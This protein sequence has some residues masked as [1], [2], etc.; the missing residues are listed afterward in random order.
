MRE[1][2]TELER[3]FFHAGKKLPVLYIEYMNYLRKTKE[4]APGTINNRKKPVL[5]FIIRHSSKCSPSNIKRVTQKEVQDYT[6]ETAAP[7]SRNLKRSLVIALRD[8][9][10][11][12]HLYEHTN[13]DLSLS[14]PT[15]TTYRMSAIPRGMPWKTVEK[16]LQCISKRTFS[17][18]RDY[19]IVLTLSRY[20][21]RA[22]QLRELKL[23]DIDWHNET[24]TF[25][26]VKGG[27][28]VVAPLYKDVAEAL[29]SYIKSGRKNAPIEYENVF[30]TS[31]TGGS[32]TM[33]QVPLNG[34]TWN[35]INRY[36]KKAGF[37][38]VIDHA[39]GPHAIRHAFATRLL[40][41]DTPI[42]TISDMIGHNSIA[43][44]FIYTKTSIPKLK[45]LELPWP[46]PKMGDVK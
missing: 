43:T 11:F 1:V 38:S 26:A 17:G 39:R 28:D 3:D 45:Q 20:G 13:I 9:F 30:L 33:G 37:G 7:L 25:K 12:L 16:V 15:I 19:A 6:M 36:L 31:G 10:R 2:V 18:K 4:L 44:T 46:E 34:S 24:V 23:S 21:V 40:D 22:C 27:K 41:Q 32:Q 8:F 14:V 29:I 5:E 42:K 35:I